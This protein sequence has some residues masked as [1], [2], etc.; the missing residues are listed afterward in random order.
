MRNVLICCILLFTGSVL[1]G[2]VVVSDFEEFIPGTPG[3]SLLVGGGILDSNGFLFTANNTNPGIPNTNAAVFDSNNATDMASNSTDFLGW[4]NA[5][6][7]VR[8]P[9]GLPF[10]LESFGYG[11]L[12]GAFFTATNVEM[13]FSNGSLT[14]TTN[15]TINTGTFSPSA[16]FR[17]VDLT[18]LTFRASNSSLP[19]GLDNVQF[20]LTAVPEPSSISILGLGVVSLLKR[21][22][23]VA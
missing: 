17:A 5:I 14:E 4:S 16:A 23:R 2:A 21:R 3:N 1:Q 6:I 22:K 20:S 13:T 7:T 15:P 9:D 18:T 10:R 11:S 8:R 19:I 12:S